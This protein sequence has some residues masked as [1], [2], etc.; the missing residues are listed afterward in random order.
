MCYRFLEIRNTALW[1]VGSG[2]SGLRSQRCYAETSE[3]E[4]RCGC[5]IWTAARN[6]GMWG[7]DKA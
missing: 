5:I 3:N 1:V 4:T 7:Y 2:R 6:F